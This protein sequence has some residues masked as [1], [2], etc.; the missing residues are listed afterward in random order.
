MSNNDNDNAIL[1]TAVEALEK[2]NKIQQDLNTAEKELK[3]VLEKINVNIS[4]LLAVRKKIVS[5]LGPKT[6]EAV[7][8]L[9]EEL[10][11]WLPPET[12]ESPAETILDSI[13]GKATQT[14][15]SLETETPTNNEEFETVSEDISFEVE[16]EKV[17]RAE[18][19][20]DRSEDWDNF[21]NDLD[22]DD[23]VD[24][25]EF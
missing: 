14:D 1:V 16:T 20:L 4:E 18:P 23:N 12:G 19:V 3:N 24:E 15:D 6:P 5:V 2:F 22:L 11:E 13:K 25:I 17:S 7:L 10:D 21:F 8:K 9:V